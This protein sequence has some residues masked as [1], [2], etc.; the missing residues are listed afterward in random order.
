ML[1][2]Y[3]PDYYAGEKKDDNSP[4]EQPPEGEA[5]NANKV[6]IIVA[7]N[8]H[9]PTNTVELVFDP[10]HTAFLGIERLRHEM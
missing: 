2:L 9:G 6:E 3:R 8:R 1:M 10:E 4:E 5:P 7:K